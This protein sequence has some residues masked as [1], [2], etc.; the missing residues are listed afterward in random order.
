MSKTYLVQRPALIGSEPFTAV[1]KKT[2]VVV[3]NGTLP[4]GRKDLILLHGP[5]ANL[6]QPMSCDETNGVFSCIHCGE[7]VS[8]SNTLFAELL[9]DI[10]TGKFNGADDDGSEV[11]LVIAHLVQKIPFLAHFLLYAIECD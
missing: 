10:S 4:S 5:H 8:V 9:S 2:L 11:Y 3:Y 6:S 7:K 1:G